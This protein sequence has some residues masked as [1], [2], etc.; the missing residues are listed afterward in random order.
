MEI[1]SIWVGLKGIEPN[2][3]SDA[4]PGLQHLGPVENSSYAFQRWRGP[5]L[6]DLAPR[7]D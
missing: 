2:I 7:R 4:P 1:L 6:F 5:Y 3:R